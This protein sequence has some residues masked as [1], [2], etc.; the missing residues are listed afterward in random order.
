MEDTDVVCTLQVESSTIRKFILY[1]ELTGGELELF[2]VIPGS[3]VIDS[4]ATRLI[5]DKSDYQTFRNKLEGASSTSLVVD[6]E[7]F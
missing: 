4:S 1:P 5:P 6:S 7:N 2:L 3:P